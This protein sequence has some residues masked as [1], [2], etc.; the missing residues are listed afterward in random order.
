MIIGEPWLLQFFVWVVWCLWPLNF[1]PVIEI[2][3]L[4]LHHP[5]GVLPPVTE[6]NMKSCSHACSWKHRERGL[7][8]SSM[9]GPWNVGKRVL[10]HF[11]SVISHFFLSYVTLYGKLVPWHSLPLT[12]TF[13]FSGYSNALMWPQLEEGKRKIIRK[14]CFT[15]VMDVLNLFQKGLS[16]NVLSLKSDK[17]GWFPLQQEV[18][19]LAKIG[20]DAP[21]PPAPP[22][23]VKRGIFSA[24][25]TSMVTIKRRESDAR[26]STQLCYKKRGQWYKYLLLQIHI[27]MIC[28]GIEFI[29]CSGYLSQ[30]IHSNMT[31]ERVFA[32]LTSILANL[33][34]CQSL[35]RAQQVGYHGL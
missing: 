15:T 31:L 35:I 13:T 20:G 14:K 9:H 29:F 21:P 12:F 17:K 24:R 4:D 5:S 30:I 2:W 3:A 8:A 7:I 33:S 25:E 27:T 18:V 10:F 16:R 32:T 28:F 34:F 11:N 26:G 6:L 23:S 1:A 22:K 19:V